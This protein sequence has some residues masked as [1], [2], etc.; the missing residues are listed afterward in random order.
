MS[1]FEEMLEDEGVRISFS[2][3]DGNHLDWIREYNDLQINSIMGI[4]E[5]GG[6]LWRLF[7]KSDHYVCLYNSHLEKQ[8]YQC[9][10][11]HREGYKKIRWFRDI[12]KLQMHHLDYEN[13]ATGKDNVILI[14]K[15]CHCKK[16]RR[17]V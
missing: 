11:C 7:I 14:C 16:H 9:F 17:N 10:S 12:P 4:G 5:R 6:R 13:Y 3:Y 1:E 15:Y 8:N 2:F